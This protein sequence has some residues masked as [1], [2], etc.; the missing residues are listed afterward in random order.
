[1]NRRA[2]LLTLA[3]AVAAPASAARDDLLALVRAARGQVGVT[4]RYDPAYTRLAYPNGDVPTERGVCTDV[5]IRAYRAAYGCD[6]QRLVH[7]DMARAFHAYPR[8]WGMARPDRNI[9]HR[10]VPNLQTFF[11]RRQARL[12]ASGHGADF[13]PGD[14]V[15]V[16]LPGHLPHIMIVSERRRG[17]GLPLVIHNIGQGAREE[18]YLFGSPHTG[19]YR[20]MPWRHPGA[21]RRPST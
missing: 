16:M 13:Q 6:L 10:R 15:T 17:D 19:H 9:D 5:V 12:P 8:T 21:A 14:L 11:A 3:A 2:F 7:E 1:L 4:L 18:D 20:F